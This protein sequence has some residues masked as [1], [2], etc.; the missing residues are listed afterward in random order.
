MVPLSGDY[1]TISC[2]SKLREQV[3]L[4]PLP[5]QD[6]LLARLRGLKGGRERKGARGRRDSLSP[7]ANG[8]LSDVMDM[9]FSSVVVQVGAA[10]PDRMIFFIIVIVL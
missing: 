9:G 6:S 4:L 7:L 1:P 5:P 10:V 3:Q 2:R 8:S